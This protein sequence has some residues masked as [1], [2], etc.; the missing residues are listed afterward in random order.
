[1]GDYDNSEQKIFH[2]LGT[3][4][5]NLKFHNLL[6]IQKEIDALKKSASDVKVVQMKLYDLPYASDDDD[7]IIEEEDN[8][9]YSLSVK[10]FGSEKRDILRSN[11]L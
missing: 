8:F 10:L 3:G 4:I 2:N 5:S 9:L 11:I 6:V 1:M 7:G